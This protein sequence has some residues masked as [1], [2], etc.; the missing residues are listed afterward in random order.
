MAFADVSARDLMIL[1]NLYVSR[2]ADYP[3]SVCMSRNTLTLFE[4]ASRI[5][6]PTRFTAIVHKTIPQLVVVLALALDCLPGSQGK[7]CCRAVG[8]PARRARCTGVRAKIPSFIL[9]HQKPGSNLNGVNNLALGEKKSVRPQCCESEKYMPNL[10][11]K[12]PKKDICLFATGPHAV[13]EV[14]P[15]GACGQGGH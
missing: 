4:T 9:T 13:H 6:V 3:L 8:A 14:C 5:P 11:P 10:C 2:R 15:G 1:R 7:Q 12:L